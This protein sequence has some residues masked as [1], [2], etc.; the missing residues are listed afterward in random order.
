M[1]APS[2]S[3]I[4]LRRGNSSARPLVERR[5]PLL[6]LPVARSGGTVGTLESQLA[7]TS[8]DAFVVL[9]DGDLV[10]EWYAE[11]NDGATLQ[12]LM[13][14]TKSVVGCLAGVLVDGGRLDP[15][16]AVTRFVPEVA[17]T[18]YAAAT[19][20]D[21][22]DMRTGGDYRESYDDEDGEVV[23]LGER[24]RGDAPGGV[25]ALVGGTPRLASHAGPFCY[26]SLDTELLGWVIERAGGKPVGELFE[27]LLLT[28]LGVE[29]DGSLGVDPLGSGSVSG[30]LA[31]TARDVAR[32][33]Q[34]LLDGGAVGRRQVVPSA[35]IK[36]TRMGGA[37]SVDA[38]RRR[39]TDGLVEA[40]NPP[41]AMYRNQFWVLEQ[42]GHRLL[43]LG[44]YGQYV[45]VDG[46][47]RTVVVKLSSWPRPQDPRLF[48]A[49]LAC[50]DAVVDHLSGHLRSPQLSLYS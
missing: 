31:L 6:D 15:D 18:G 26:R 23:R 2:G 21:L 4:A 50:A 32:F 45:H 22:L 8:T 24:L 34:M 5:V 49:G 1:M 19:V 44:I 43:A 41:S 12:A 30:G 20:R 14:V 9:H 37:D 13:S 25:R 42:G 27:Q 29:Y 36:D 33:G 3:R 46:D 40:P 48:T 28:P 35:W 16:L 47:A 10:L 39:V 38:F 7:A 17:T 11:P